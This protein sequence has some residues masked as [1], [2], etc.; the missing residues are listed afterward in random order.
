MVIR[1]VSASRKRLADLEVAG[2]PDCR[3][4]EGKTLEK[5]DQVDDVAA[6]PAACSEAMKASATRAHRELPAGVPLVDGAA[7]FEPTSRTPPVRVSDS[8]EDSLDRHGL[9]DLPVVDSGIA[10]QSSAFGGRI[11]TVV[12]GAV[13]K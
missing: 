9:L 5:R 11:W 4:S 1:W 13:G 8:V 12:C 7:G 10:H 3:V 6:L 2:E